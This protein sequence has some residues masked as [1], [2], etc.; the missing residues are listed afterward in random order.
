MSGILQK[1][2]FLEQ[3]IRENNILTDKSEAIINM[4]EKLQ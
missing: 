1:E 3:K 4:L 2:K